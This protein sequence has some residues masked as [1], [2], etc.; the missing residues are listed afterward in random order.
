LQVMAQSDVNDP[1][2]ARVLAALSQ[3]D[4]VASLDSIGT[5]IWL[6][7]MDAY[8]AATW[9]DDWTARGIE[10]K[11]GSWGFSGDNQREPMLEVLEYITRENPSAIWFD[12]RATPDREL[13]DDIVRRAFANTVE[14]LKKDV[15]EDLTKYAWRNFNILKVR[16][17]L[18]V[19]ELAREGGPVPG[20]SFTVNPGGD[21]GAVGGGAS[22]RMIVDF[23]N[24]ST[25]VG[26]YPGGQSENPESS[27]YSDQM[28]LWAS[29]TYAP[30]R[31]VSTVDA[32]PADSV[33]QSLTLTP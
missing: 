31:A 28:K 32:L 4:Y 20:D 26:T 13:R 27:H 12:D 16:S 21:G 11:G 22:W 29:G 30:I 8:R 6:R 1:F 23:S 24:L 17:M 5:I 9:D 25:S 10:A 15:G 18:P 3:W 14:S 7:W 2:S 19:P 33:K